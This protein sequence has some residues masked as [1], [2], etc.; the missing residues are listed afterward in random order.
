MGNSG[1]P[2]STVVRAVSGRDSN[3]T[4]LEYQPLIVAA[5]SNSVHTLS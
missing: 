3:G 4:T 5:V 1:K 2:R